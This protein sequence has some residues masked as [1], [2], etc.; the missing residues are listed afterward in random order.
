E[1]RRILFEVLQGLQAVH[2]RDYLH[3]DIKPSNIYLRRDGHCMLIDFGA[4]RYAL[5]EH[6]R[7]LMG[8]MTPGYAP[9][10]Q[11]SLT[12]KQGPY[13]DIYA[14]GATIYRCLTMRPPV[15]AAERIAAATDGRNDPYVPISQTAAGGYSDALLAVIDWMLQLRS[16]DRPQTVAEVLDVLGDKPTTPRSRQPVAANPLEETVKL[17]LTPATGTLRIQH[18]EPGWIGDWFRRE[19][20]TLAQRLFGS[21]GLQ[22]LRLR[23]NQF[24]QRQ[25]EAITL[26]I[27]GTSTSLAARW[28]RFEASR[29]ARALAGLT[30]ILFVLLLLSY[31][32]TPWQQM[33]AATTQ[34][35]A[36]IG[37][38]TETIIIPAGAS[39]IGNPAV[40]DDDDDLY[41]QTFNIAQPFAMGRHE[42]SFEEYDR[43]CEATRRAKPADNGWGRGKRPVI[44]VSWQDA[45]AYAAWL[46]AQ[47]GHRFRLPSEAE[48]EYAARGARRTNYAW[49]NQIGSGYA[50]CK[51]CGSPWDGKQTAPTGSFA[52]NPFGLQDTAGNVAEWTCSIFAGTNVP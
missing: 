28:Q 23:L 1:V 51:G 25:Y 13:T 18:G 17:P 33:Q 49:G 37:P 48:W 31:R 35:A 27:L 14:T 16:V 24:G 12:S 21:P 8:M 9:Y 43:F 20:H 7:S 36:I 15:E 5:G 32:G 34:S 2:A 19:F 44:N 52:L 3:R 6:S 22:R 45:S 26:W 11:Y 38:L 10:E 30:G 50:N 42:V 40:D 46:S 29:R 4:A 41:P 47:T 39:V